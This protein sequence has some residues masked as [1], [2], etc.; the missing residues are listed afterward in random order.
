MPVLRFAVTG[1]TVY[2]IVVHRFLGWPLLLSGSSETAAMEV[3]GMTASSD[4]FPRFPAVVRRITSME[5][6][7]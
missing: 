1:H 4:Q 3:S 7:G 2:A 5:N 6:N